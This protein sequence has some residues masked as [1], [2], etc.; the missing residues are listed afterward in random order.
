MSIKCNLFLT[1]LLTLFI[2]PVFLFSQQT[3]KSG[4]IKYEISKIES[5]DPA[6]DA[7]L[8]MLQGGT[9]TL[10]FNQQTQRVDVNMMGGMMQTTSIVDVDKNEVA[11]YMDMMGQ[12][13]KMVTE[14]ED[15]TAMADSLKKIKMPDL[16]FHKNDKKEI[17][18][19]PCYRVDIKT[20][21]EGQ[22][23]IITSYITDK[24]KVPQQSIQNVDVPNLPGAVLSYSFE[25]MGMKM[26]YDA[27]EV[28]KEVDPSVFEFSSEGYR[29]MDPEQFQQQF[30]G[31]G[32]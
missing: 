25:M 30:G 15:Y 21:A 17:A 5:D 31:M 6:M 14:K 2:S 24:I 1:F 13:I 22:E 20:E 3:L 32:Q 27:V 29:E 19:Y 18:G 23:I 16:E 10:Y 4:S 7:Q 26:Q 8:Q 9:I 28:E 12:K 11:T